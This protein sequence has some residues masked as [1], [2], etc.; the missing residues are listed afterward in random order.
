MR[1]CYR[2]G[3]HRTHP[4]THPEPYPEHMKKLAA[5]AA[6]P[7]ALTAC[8]SGSSDATP[9]SITVAGS[10]SLESS[11][12]G[13]DIVD[14]DYVHTDNSSEYK[15]GD[16]CEGGNG[17]DDL[18]EGAQVTVADE[19]GKTLGLGNLDAGKLDDSN[20]CVFAFTVPDVSSEAKFYT[21]KVSHREGPQ[22]TREQVDKRVALTIG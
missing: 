12:Y 18:I 8:S 1:R 22:Y 20:H 5:L 11:I 2:N 9:K 14:R 17:Y 21:V 16:R 3:A 10:V 4:A 15:A 7:L 19:S 13:G 6:L